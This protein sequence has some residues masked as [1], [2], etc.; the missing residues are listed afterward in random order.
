MFYLCSVNM[1]YNL[2]LI[3]MKRKNAKFAAKRVVVGVVVEAPGYIINLLSFSA[4]T[5]SLCIIIQ[6]RHNEA[7]LQLFPA[8]R[9]IVLSYSLK[10]LRQRLPHLLVERFCIVFLRCGQFAV[11]QDELDFLHVQ[12]VLV[13]QGCT[14]MTT[15]MPM[16]MPLDPCFISDVPQ[17]VIA[18]LVVAD[19]SQSLQR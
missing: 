14:G 18:F 11:T 10:S 2:N 9:L 3:R 19:V 7:R 12:P 16:Q 17:V 8:E 1:F 15:Q 5:Q 4:D 6:C 13:E